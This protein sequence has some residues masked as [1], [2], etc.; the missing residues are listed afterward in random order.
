MRIY[1]QN[2]SAPAGGDDAFFCDYDSFF[3]ESISRMYQ[4]PLGGMM[5]FVTMIV[6]FID[7]FFIRTFQ[8][9]NHLFMIIYFFDPSFGL[10]KYGNLVW[11]QNK[12]KISN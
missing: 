11:R 2:V 3:C 6:F 9:S 7:D 12:F 8:L 1:Q 5:H 10:F 4:P